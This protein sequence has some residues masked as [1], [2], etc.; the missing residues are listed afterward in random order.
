MEVCFFMVE[1]AP[2]GVCSIVT[3][4]QY[5]VHLVLLHIYMCVCMSGINW[6]YDVIA[7]LKGV[8]SRGKKILYYGLL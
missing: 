4:R 8:K 7:N 5:S 6:N 1:K 2:F 3:L